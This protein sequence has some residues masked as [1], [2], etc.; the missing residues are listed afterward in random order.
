[1]SGSNQPG[2]ETTTGRL[3]WA[4]SLIAITIFLAIIIVELFFIF[5]ARTE[6]GQLGDR[7]ATLEQQVKKGAV[8]QSPAEITLD[9]LQTETEQHRTFIEQQQQLLLW[10]VGVILAL[11]TGLIGFLGWK[12]KDD[13][14]RLIREKYDGEIARQLERSFGS[15]FDAKL[16]KT[17]GDEVNEGEKLKFL[18]ESVKRISYM[19]EKTVLFVTQDE[20]SS[21]NAIRHWLNI[22][23]ICKTEQVFKDSTDI[24]QQIESMRL[25]SIVAYEVEQGDN[26]KY[27]DI[28][29]ACSNQRNEC[30]LLC[31]NGKQ[32]DLTKLDAR[33]TTTVNFPSKLRET[34]YTL[35]SFP[36]MRY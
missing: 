5:S 6:I 16:K 28:A 9:F 3:K 10:L 36:P 14:D 24:R 1:M 32:V 19:H 18:Q 25:A 21:W 2:S 22:Y 27:L 33:Y 8:A 12:S 29:A 4:C 13:V 34:L 30:I 7:I 17:I 31:A 20:K 23:G 11:A 26:T 15:T 35:L